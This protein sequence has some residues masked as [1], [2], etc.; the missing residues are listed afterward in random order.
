MTNRASAYV[1]A[2]LLA[3]PLL[4]GCGS[5]GSKSTSGST[6]AG[7]GTS[8]TSSGG[9]SQQ[10]AGPETV[11][12]ASTGVGTILVDGEGKTIYLFQKDRGPQSTC[13][14]ACLAH[15]P[16]VTTTGKPQAGSGV[17]AS[18]LST[19]RRS[20][21]TTQVT[22]AGHP[23]YYFSGDSSAGAM[24][25]QGVAAFGADWYVLGPN[26]KKVEGH[27][28]SSGGGSGSTSSKGSY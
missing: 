20:D 22:Y 15:W 18:M 24:S 21:G 27:G 2:A 11:K 13:S 28:S 1:V 3:L 9:S 8:S 4:A 19:S 12:T 6:A 7:G 10:G 5:S 14:G 16:A 23:L 26:G 25:G 17:T